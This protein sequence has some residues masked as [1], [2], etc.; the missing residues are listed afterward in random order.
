MEEVSNESNILPIN[1]ISEKIYFVRGENVMLDKDLAILFEV[2]TIRLREQVKRN[3]EKFPLHFLFQLTNNEIEMMVS[4]NAI[5]S[6]QHLGGAL[7][8][9]FTEYGVLQLA[10]VLRSKTATKMS[11]R[12]IEVFIKMRELLSTHKEIL[13]KI[14]QLEQKGV[15]SDKN[16]TA[17]FEYLKQLEK[18]RNDEIEFKKRP[19]VGYRSSKSL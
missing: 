8:Y 17:I 4:Q 19:R 12:I 6:R 9:V 15:E 14:E 18:L 16:F 5:P 10:N 11:I 3:I 2:K 1:I 13:Y 7:P